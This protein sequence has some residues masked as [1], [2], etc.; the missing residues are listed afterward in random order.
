MYV[1]V[2]Y[3]GSRWGIMG[4]NY[5]INF[6]M[7]RSVNWFVGFVVVQVSCGCLAD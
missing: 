5:S 4:E 7:S 6:L 3:L 1:V 2:Y